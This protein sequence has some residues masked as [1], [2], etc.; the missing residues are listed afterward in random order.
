M[1]RQRIHPNNAQ[2][3][4]A[5]RHRLREKLQHTQNLLANLHH[6]LRSTTLRGDTPCETLANL[7]NWLSQATSPNATAELLTQ[8]LAELLQ[9][10]SQRTLDHTLET[11]GATNDDHDS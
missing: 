5:Y 4:F 3:Q 6:L 7:I 1:P 9:H 10:V 8:L 11:K 2:K